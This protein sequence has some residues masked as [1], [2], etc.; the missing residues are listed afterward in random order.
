MRNPHVG[1]QQMPLFTPESAWRAPE[2]LPDLRGKDLEIVEDCETRDEMLAAGRGPGWAARAGYVAGVSWT[3]REYGDIHSVYVPIRHPDTPCHDKDAVSRWMRDHRADPRLRWLYQNAN[4]DLGWTQADL[5]AEP[6][7]AIGDTIAM[8]VM[9]DE[10]QLSY[11]LDSLCRW[12]RVPGK[13]EALLREAAA[14]Y[15]FRDVK[16]NIWQLPGRYAGPYAEQDGV[17]TLL[18]AESLRPTLEAEGTTAA[19]QLECDLI[20]M[21]VEMRRRGV[22]V[23]T[24][25]AEELYAELIANRDDAL[26]DLSHRMARSV[27][28]DNVRSWRWMEEV[29]T[30]E[31]IKFPRTE[32]TEQ[33]SFQAKWMR[34]HEHWLPSLAA[35]AE[36]LTEA[37]EKFV[38]GYI[39]DY[40]HRGRLHAQVNQFR[41]E[42]GGTRSHRFSYADPP[43][44]Q[45]PSRDEDIAPRIR[46]CFEPEEGETWLSADVKQQE[47]KLIVHFAALVCLPRAAEAVDRYVNDPNTDF[48]SMVA[49]MTGLP[50]RSAKD[51]NF[52][53]AFG[54]G[55]KKFAT[56]IGKPE[57]EAREIM[58]QYDK[59][60]PFVKQLGQKCKY[61]ASARGYVVLI[62][63]AR[64]HFDH[65]EPAWREEDEPYVAPRALAEARELFGDN[66]RLRRAWTHKA[67]NRLIQG[68][69][70]RQTKLWMRL[71]WR[72]GLVPLLQ[73]HDELDFSVREEAQG[74]RVAEL[75]AQSY[76]L[77][78]P[79][80]S[81]LEYGPTW[82][83]SAKV[84]LP[85]KS[86]PYRGTWEEAQRLRAEGQWW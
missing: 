48:H 21:V 24:A 38:R 64:S 57:D 30:A 23:N 17:S 46:D 49:E 36:Q 80:T 41:N 75:L 54:A 58:D 86:V 6:P 28:I 16:A 83:K 82:G 43:L 53:K 33:G 40:A 15:G 67:M 35:R 74:R 13:D 78:M 63:G 51:T 47:Y 26:A 27:T 31:G 81:D 22:R 4:Y 11:D 52:A 8:A 32:K 29:F 62:D 45:M 66:R 59:E 20:P 14:A 5:G 70:A 10:N 73:M 37:A 44:Q 7:A 84:E 55:V 18:L 61:L 42:D 76:E 60:M 85:D 72:E 71:C 34:K 19:Y 68:S 65:W 39:I 12:R 25:R 79:T 1:G 56:M 3:W 50:R 77:L 9:V 69:A 2:Q